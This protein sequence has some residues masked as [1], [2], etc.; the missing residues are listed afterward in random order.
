MSECEKYLEMISAQIDNELSPEEETELERHLEGCPSCRRVKEAFGAIS[1][2]VDEELV[3]PPEELAASVMQKIRESDKCGGDRK[4]KSRNSKRIYLKRYLALA[5]CAALIIFTASSQ[6]PNIYNLT[7]KSAEPQAADTFM[8]NADAPASTEGADEVEAQSLD[9][10]DEDVYVRSTEGGEGGAAAPVPEP[11]EVP[12]EKAD[13]P[14]AADSS[15]MSEGQMTA[16]YGAAGSGQSMG[17]MLSELFSNWSVSLSDPGAA[18]PFFSFAD[19][20][21]PVTL[22]GF[23][24]NALDEDAGAVPGEEPTVIINLSGDERSCWLSVWSGGGNILCLYS[25]LSTVSAEKGEEI[26]FKTDGSAESF[27]SYIDTLR[28][29]V[30]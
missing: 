4:E 3:Q 28:N 26:F 21:G 30:S 5:A 18:E 22:L 1:G 13:V 11:E 19:S 27:N 15:Q 10:A 14:E 16:S 25:E 8:A 9:G 6:I 12:A 24:G 7:R 17:D 29:L 23:L 2:A 20:E